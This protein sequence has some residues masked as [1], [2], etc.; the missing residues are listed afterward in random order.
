MNRRWTPRKW[1][2]L[3]AIVGLAGA[4]SAIGIA[5]AATT[6][7]VDQSDGIA[8]KRLPKTKFQP[9]SLNVVVSS[10]TDPAGEFPVAVT[11]TRLDFD[12]DGKITTKGLKVCRADLEGTTTEAARSMCRPSMVGKGTARAQVPGLG[13]VNAVVSAFNGP[14]QGPNATI[15]LHART[16]LG[17]TTVLTGTISR[18]NQGD[19]GTRLNVPVEPLPAGAV[20]TRFETTVEKKWRFRGKTYNYITARCHDGNK[21]LNIKGTFEL[22]DN[23]TGTPTTQTDTDTQ[24]CRVKR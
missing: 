23:D 12:D 17:T 19:Y 2:A 20:L 7:S 24:K 4:L 16:T 11:N 15:I 14:K 22:A 21:T 13:N 18:I 9:A 3:V 6:V 8:P 10:T 1:G 5:S